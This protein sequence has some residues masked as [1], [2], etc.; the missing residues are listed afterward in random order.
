MRS[1][2][3]DIYCPDRKMDPCYQSVFV[4]FDIENKQ[5]VA[6]AISGIETPL[7]FMICPEIC[8]MHCS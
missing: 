3:P 2:K 5:V 6:N 4:A 7:H 1:D 8:L